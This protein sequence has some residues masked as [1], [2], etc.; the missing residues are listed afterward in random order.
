MLSHLLIPLCVSAALQSSLDSSVRRKSLANG[1]EVIVV[2][3]SAV[4]LATALVAVRNGAFT[5]DLDEAGLAH[6]YE[7]LL[8]HSFRHNPEAFAIEASKLKGAVP[9][10]GAYASTAKP[11]QVLPLMQD[12]VRVLQAYPL[13]N[14]V[15]SRFLDGHNFEYLVDNATAADQADF[16]ARAELYLGGYQRGD[17]FMKRLRWV[18]PTD[19]MAAASLYMS[20]LQYAYLGDTARMR[21]HW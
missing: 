4:P 9:L 21:G 19:V 2:P 5:Q 3:N 17:E 6:L 18:S 14:F 1:L 16:L 7:H 8:F 20:K 11:D 12:A 10:G 15:L 13:D